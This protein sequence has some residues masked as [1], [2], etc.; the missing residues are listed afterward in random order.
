MPKDPVVA[1]QTKIL[2]RLDRILANQKTIQQNQKKL[3]RILTN[4]KTIQQNQ[5]KLDR[6]VTNQGKILE[7]LSGKKRSAKSG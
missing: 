5:K 3:D 1:N 2:D 6:I 7:K 4:Q